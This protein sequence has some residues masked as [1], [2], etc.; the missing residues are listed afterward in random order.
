MEA[1]SLFSYSESYMEFEVSHTDE[2]F[3]VS[4]RTELGTFTSLQNGLGQAFG[5]LALNGTLRHGRHAGSSSLQYQIGPSLQNPHVNQRVAASISAHVSIGSRLRADVNLFGAVERGERSGAY[6]GTGARLAYDAPGGGVLALAVHDH[7]SEGATYARP[8]EYTLSYTIPFG[9]PRPGSRSAPRVRGRL[10][11]LAG[12]PIANVIVRIGDRAVSTDAGGAFTLPGHA[13]EVRYLDID[14]LSLGLR[15]MPY[16]QMP[17]AIEPGQRDEIVITVGES[18]RLDGQIEAHGE[19]ALPPRLLVEI[20]DGEARFRAMADR[21]GRFQ[22][23][24]LRPG[25]WQVSIV[26]GLSA[27]LVLNQEVIN[28]ELVGGEAAVARFEVRPR[29]RAIEIIR[30]G[31]LRAR[32]P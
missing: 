30:Q 29:E 13:S 19:A 8:L 9:I 4:Q 24:D 11:D 14:R 26:S 18:A 21:H 25:A 15:R 23:H 32:E 12:E 17:M 2:A 28:V 6:L 1:G 16:A 5:R 22:F 27:D 3:E 20:G 31:T 10:I 7:R